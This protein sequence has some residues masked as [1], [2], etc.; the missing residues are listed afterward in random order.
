MNISS[1][2]RYCNWFIHLKKPTFSANYSGAF[3]C[4][5][6]HIEDTSIP[7]LV[8]LAQNFKT[9]KFCLNYRAKYEIV[10]EYLYTT[11]QNYTH[12]IWIKHL[13]N[14]YWMLYPRTIQEFLIETSDHSFTYHRSLFM[15]KLR[16]GQF[17]NRIWHL[18]VWKVKKLTLSIEYFLII[19]IGFLYR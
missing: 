1:D 11:M 6:D 12:F 19:D 5:P 8:V 16:D 9:P 18:R 10:T 13:N 14:V 15:A 7:D 2:N 3:V 17:S 4:N